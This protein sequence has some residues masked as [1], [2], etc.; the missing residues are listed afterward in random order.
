[1]CGI[2]G[3]VG[4]P[5]SPDTIH[6]LHQCM[7]GRGPDQNGAWRDAMCTLV[8]ARLAVIDIEGGIQPMS[9]GN[10]VIVYNGEIYNTEEVRTELAACGR[11]FSGHSDTEVVL[12]AYEEWGADCLKKLNGIFAF[13]IWDGTRLFAARDRMGV[14]PFFYTEAGGLFC[15]ASELKG[16]LTFPHMCAQLDLNGICEVM[17]LGP[18][19]T[20]GCGVF[21]GI[22]ELPPAYCGYY[23]PGY[24]FSRWRYWDIQE[25]PHIE[26]FEETA[27]HVKE[28]VLDSI[29]RQLVSDVPIC[30]FLSGG[31]DSSLISSVAAQQARNNGK[32][33][34]TVSVTYKEN[35][36][37]FQ[38]GHFQP[39]SDESYIR[40]MNRYLDSDHHLIE[41]DTPELAEALYDAVDA[42]DLPGMADVDASLLLF[43][44][45]IKK[46]GTVAL[47][48]E[49]AD[50]IFG[51][52][53]WY[54]DRDIR[55]TDGFPWAQSTAYRTGFLREEWAQQVDAEAY[56]YQKYRDTIDAV[57]KP[58]YLSD[59]DCRMREMTRLNLNWFMQT[60]L[61]ALDAQK[62][63]IIFV[64]DSQKLHIASVDSKGRT[65]Y[66]VRYQTIYT[67]R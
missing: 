29:T 45:Q 34:S 33:L 62:I 17:L 39:N 42:R 6:A 56:V 19:R 10:Q 15:F 54:R 37:Y 4:A 1:M 24:G 8:H 49:C 22:C 55:M 53:P 67:G 58:A 43:C 46:I 32:K 64:G 9:L 16:I 18:G 48:G 57:Q 36:K 20:P 65:Y 35:E 41:I 3:L 59:V 61:E 14:K 21:R 30:T 50:E 5:V 52:Y 47:S 26:S 51:G 25:K 63:T 31:L 23:E 7:A 2:A 12:H 66:N 44:R 11:K 60:L 40:M 28:L 27:A 38:P 13:A